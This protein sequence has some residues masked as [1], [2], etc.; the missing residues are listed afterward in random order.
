[1]DNRPLIESLKQMIRQN[2]ERLNAP[3]SGAAETIIKRILE[4][5]ETRETI[6]EAQRL[7]KALE[8]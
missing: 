2:E 8:G 3:R 4:D 1:M 7:L 5:E 6:R